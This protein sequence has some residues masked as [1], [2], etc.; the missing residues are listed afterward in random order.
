MARLC[1]PHFCPFPRALWILVE[2][3]AEV[4]V[5]E[6]AVFFPGMRRLVEVATLSPT[7]RG[8]RVEALA[9]LLRGACGSGE[10]AL[11]IIL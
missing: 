1:F 8:L 4:L 11:A 2:V 6:L 5:M 7:A 9:T 3:E 10:E